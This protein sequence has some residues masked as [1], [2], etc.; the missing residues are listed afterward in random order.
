MNEVEIIDEA[1]KV[2][3][4]A[5]VSMAQGVLEVDCSEAVGA[6]G[7]EQEHAVRLRSAGKLKRRKMG[8]AR[9]GVY[10]IGN[11]R[12]GRAWPRPTATLC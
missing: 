12:R 5:G 1:L 6:R 10:S 11:C 3:Q 7:A 9:G 8:G 4:C 2:V